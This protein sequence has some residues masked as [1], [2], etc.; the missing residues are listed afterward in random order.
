MINSIYGANMLLIL[1]AVKD[2]KVF[3]MW[4]KQTLSSTS[5]CMR[6]GKDIEWQL[7]IYKT[8]IAHMF[9]HAGVQSE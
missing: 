9:P 7:H 2:V 4:L 6:E 8:T 3:G 5:Y 1:F